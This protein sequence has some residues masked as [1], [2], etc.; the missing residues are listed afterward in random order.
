MV[1]MNKQKL[2]S[3]FDISQLNIFFF[4][5]SRPNASD[6]ISFPEYV[7]ILNERYVNFISLFYSETTEYMHC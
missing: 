1:E 5:Y 4:K 3:L 7:L 6:L 2:M